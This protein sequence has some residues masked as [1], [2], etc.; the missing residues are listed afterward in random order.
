MLYI[1]I[2]PDDKNALRVA[3]HRR[4]IISLGRGI[5][6]DEPDRDPAEQVRHNMLAIV[7]RMLPNWHLAYSSAATLAPI[8]NFV[9]VSGPSTTHAPIVLPGIRIVRD[10]DLPKPEVD[11]IEAPT[12]VASSLSAEPQV[13]KVGVSSPLQTVFDCLAASRSYPEKTLPESRL[14]ELIQQLG[15]SDRDRAQAFATRNDLQSEYYRFTELLDKARHVNAV[16]VARRREFDVYFYGWEIGQLTG[17]S[18]EFRFEYGPKWDV[19]LSRQL[20]IGEKPAYEGREM[21]AFF[22]NLLPEGWMESQLQATFKIAKEDKLGLLATSQKYLSNISVR[23]AGQASAEIMFDTMK[24]KLQDVAPD[25]ATVV[26]VTDKI[27]EQKTLHDVLRG[28]GAKGPLR[29][30]G[31][32]A[33]LPVELRR[34]GERVTLNLGVLSNSCSHIIK[35]QSPV[36][37]N[38][39]ENEWA[40]M[41]LARR[42][43]LHTATVRMVEGVKSE[44]AKG[45]RALLIERYDIPGKTALDSGSVDLTLPLQEDAASLLLLSRADKYHSSAE[46]IAKALLDLRLTEP[47]LDKFLEHVIFSWL[48]ANGDLHAKNVSVIK[49]LTAGKLGLYPELARVTYSPIYDLVNTRIYID[50]DKFAMTI[51]GKNDK[52]RAKDFAAI[53]IRWGRTKADIANVMERLGNSISKNLNEVL[54]RSQLPEDRAEAYRAAV[55]ENVNG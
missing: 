22:D 21:P 15:Q 9:F 4:Q 30:S 43:G 54:E 12:M 52:L 3:A 35:Y 19:E 28:L 16:H 27:V 44:D 13:V 45:T 37:P 20:P 55:M 25:A 39:V 6:T 33:K 7:G 46:K 41:E 34:D 5:Y 42:A 8:N 38:M 10:R 53:G 11:W 24:V 17:L 47:E 26:R 40:T 49:W 32:Q 29:V 18:S 23:P 31:V 2:T 14:L 51:N 36:F 50:G 48:V 1:G